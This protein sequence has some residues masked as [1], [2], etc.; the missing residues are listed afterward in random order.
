VKNNIELDGDKKNVNKSNLESIIKQKPN[1][2]ILG[3]IRFHLRAYNFVNQDKLA[4]NRE[5]RDIKLNEKNKKR[6]A[7]GKSP[8]ESLGFSFSEWLME[9]GEEPVILDESQVKVSSNQMQLSL[10]KEGFFNATV[11]DSII[12]KGKTA[13]V[14]YNIHEGKPYTIRE[15]KYNTNDKRI[16]QIISQNLRRS[17]VSKGQNYNEANIAKER[18]RITTLL[19]NNGF[20]TITR[21]FINFRV[22]STLG[23]HQVDLYVDINNKR[24]Q[25][26]RDSVVFQKH[27]T[28]FIKNVYVITDYEVGQGELKRD[29]MPTEN[30]SYLYYR[31]LNYTPSIL[32]QHI[33]LKPNQ[34]YEIRNQEETYKKLLELKNFKF[35]NIQ[36]EE[37]YT[38]DLGQ[39]D[40]GELNCYILLTPASKQAL[41]LE[42]QGT[43]RS[44]NLGISGNLVYTNR[45]LFKGAENLEIRLRG[46]LE[47]QVLDTDK[48][49]ESKLLSFNTVEL[50]PEVKLEIPKF[51]IPINPSRFSKYFTPKTQFTAAYY[52]Q[53]RPD[54]IRRLVNMQYAYTWKS[55]RLITHILT[56]LELNFVKVEEK[57]S[58]SNFLALIDNPFI[59]NNFRDHMTSATR[60]A[61]IFSDMSMKNRDVNT[62][63]KVSVESSGNLLRLFSE[64]TNAKTNDNG[65]YLV[66]GTPFSQYLKFDIDLR[67]YRDISPKQKLAFRTAFGYGRPLDNLNVLPLEKSYFGGGAN[68][69]RA[70]PARS[71]GP[72]SFKD[73]TDFNTLRIGDINLESSL[74]YRFDIIKM[75]KGAFFL[76]AGNIWLYNVDNDREG[77]T[78]QLKNINQQIAVG[79]GFGIRLDFSFFVFRVDLGV[80]M[81]DPQ[82]EPDER[83]VYKKINNDE[84][85]QAYEDKYDRRYSFQSLN[86]GIGYPF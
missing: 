77:G 53:E 40:N 35:V 86:L 48:E 38:E 3:L 59:L 34:L 58:L 83:W 43:N 55:S 1:R 6:A 14:N 82:L 67:L 46:G 71:L 80:K 75:V 65:S 25:M 11:S 17:Q 28:F 42:V 70:W 37:I 29:T 22:D 30:L 76:D 21:D 7:K 44:G 5:K 15:I 60:Y 18:E 61:I 13:T 8:K 72:G 85:K 57:E 33:F 27:K 63:L 9:I 84:W 16:S 81:H 66:F 74:E 39:F 20:Y 68:G 54:L 31:E 73:L 78:F 2:K 32:E 56:P 69:L 36:F 26:A 10:I 51:L 79:G 64:R 62:F 49:S 47:S 50:G 41:G 23:T 24:I 4:I 12:K 52:F 45:N 19:K